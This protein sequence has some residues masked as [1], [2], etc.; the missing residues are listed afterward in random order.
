VTTSLVSSYIV[1][2]HGHLQA[3]KKRKEKHFSPPLLFHKKGQREIIGVFKNHDHG[4]DASSDKSCTSPLSG[5]SVSELSFFTSGLPLER[6]FE[7]ERFG[8]GE[9]L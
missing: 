1:F 3:K 8:V 6:D 4:D 2:S 9:I 5:F 7:S